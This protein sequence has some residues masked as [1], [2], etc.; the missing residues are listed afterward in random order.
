[1]Q[2]QALDGHMD[3]EIEIDLCRPCQSVWFDARENLQLTPGATLT[4]FR[5]IGEN[6]ARPLLQER[7]LASARAA[8][9]SCAAPRTCSATPASNTFAARTITDG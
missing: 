2:P 6:V 3:R 5:I 4:M 8:T 7:D 9:R 1:M